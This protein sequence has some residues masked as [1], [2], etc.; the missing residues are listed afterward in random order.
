MNRSSSESLIVVDCIDFFSF[1][2]PIIVSDLLVMDYFFSLLFTFIV[3]SIACL[4]DARKFCSVMTPF[5]T[6]F[7]FMSC[8]F[9]RRTSCRMVLCVPKHVQASFDQSCGSECPESDKY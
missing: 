7:A 2:F 1:I 6:I 4:M 3:D 9:S 8:I 5:L